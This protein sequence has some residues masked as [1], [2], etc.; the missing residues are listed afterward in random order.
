MYILIVL[1]FN[2]GEFFMYNLLSDKLDKFEREMRKIRNTIVAKF[3]FFVLYCCKWL[4]LKF[5]PYIHT[6]NLRKFRETVQQLD[7][8]IEKE[9]EL[10]KKIQQHSKDIDM[11]IR[12]SSVLNSETMK[13]MRS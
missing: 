13:M 3:L 9:L 12:D 7:N 2:Q 10:R 5:K 6:E 1:K 8:D 11:M 4:V